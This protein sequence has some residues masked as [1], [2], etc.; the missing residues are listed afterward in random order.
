MSSPRAGQ[1][2]AEMPVRPARPLVFSRLFQSSLLENQDRQHEVGPEQSRSAPREGD[3]PG[4][5]SED[6]PGAGASSF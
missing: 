5:G 3:R 4:M 1:G 2:W 6:C